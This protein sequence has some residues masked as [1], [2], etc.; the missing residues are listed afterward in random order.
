M[1]YNKTKIDGALGQE[2]QD[3]LE[4]LGLHTPVNKT[5]LNIDNKTKI[6]KIEYHMTEVCK[7]LG[8]DL[9][10]DSLIETPKR[11]A[12]M[13]VLEDFY[14]LLPENFPKNTMIA[15]KMKTSEMVKISKI[16]VVSRCEHHIEKI[17][18]YGYVAYIPKDK[19]VGLSKISRVVDY[20]CKRPQVQERLTEQ[21]FYALEY[22]LGTED[23]A[24]Y[25]DAEHLCMTT[26]GVEDANATTST[27]KL[28]GAFKIDPATRAEFLG[29]IK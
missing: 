9:T 22:M 29:L 6:D 3:Y 25:I 15:N 23:V 24:V 13:F 4:S 21:I 5:L 8:L 17:L 14:G 28:G 1:S 26:R 27:C 20:F 19:I 16:K 18:G 7:I 10:D 12:K 2:I 11:I